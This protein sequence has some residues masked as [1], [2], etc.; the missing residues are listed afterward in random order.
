MKKTRLL[1]IL[2]TFFAFTGCQF[3][4]N[5]KNEVKIS[6]ILPL[7]GN[8][9]IVGEKAKDALLFSE[10]FFNDSLLKNSKY[11][12]KIVI[13]DGAG[14]PAT[15]ISALNKLLSI[16]KAEI[17]LSIMSP[18]D[19]AIIPIQ[20]EK[21]FL[22]ISHATHPKLSGINEL[23]FRHSPTVE[24]EFELLKKT[25]SIKSEEVILIYNNDDY[26]VALKELFNQNLNQISV[27]SLETNA[28]TQKIL[29]QKVLLKDP[30][31]IILC[32]NA[33][34]LQPQIKA[35]KESGFKGTIYTTLGYAATGGLDFFKDDK[36]IASIDFS[37][38]EKTNDF[39]KIS[40]SFKTKYKRNMSSTEIVFFNSV[41]MLVRAISENRTTPNDISNYINEKK[42]FNG[43]GEQIIVNE[44][45]DI[46][47][48]IEIHLN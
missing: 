40:D 2:I 13:E 19:L 22:F 47:P 3:R 23:V 41:Y 17:V 32:G 4:Q 44:K 20:K 46:L 12:I 43:F 35:L 6:A 7:T 15:S 34:I 42:Y 30:R 10:S 33:K 18:V 16:D 38:L 29:T 5:Q 1:F 25:I 24:Q 36:S 14:I 39:Q 27:F 9:S 37:Q 45:N 21:L 31:D 11:K 28:A 26:G 48:K 8:A